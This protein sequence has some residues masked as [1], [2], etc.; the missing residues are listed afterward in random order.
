MQAALL[1]N[2]LR[3]TSSAASSSSATCDTSKLLALAA[4]AAAAAATASTPRETSKGQKKSKIKL[5]P[6]ELAA[7]EKSLSL[8]PELTIEPIFKSLQPQA[9]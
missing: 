3:A 8:H 1:M 5:T 6:E 9:K 2:Q 7:A 4:A